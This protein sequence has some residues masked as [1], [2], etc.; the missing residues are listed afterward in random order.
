M[1]TKLERRFNMSEKIGSYKRTIIS[2]LIVISIIILAFGIV[3]GLITGSIQQFFNDFFEV[4]SPIT[5]GFVIAY[6]SSTFIGILENRI[7]RWI[8][9]LTLRRLIAILLTFSLAIFAIVFAVTMLIP[10]LLTTLQSFWDTYIVDYATAANMFAVR[11]NLIMDQFSFFDSTQRINPEE[12]V[13]MGRATPFEGWKVNG[14][15]LMTVCN[16]EIA[17]RKGEEK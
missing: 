11:V 8:K 9:S 12:F 5:I 2:T 15:C 10:N 14:E 17:W 3:Y 6:L 4:I 1:C 7:L 13:S 16:G